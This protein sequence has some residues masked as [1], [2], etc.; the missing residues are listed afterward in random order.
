MSMMC[1][2]NLRCQNSR[3]RSSTVCVVAQMRRPGRYRSRS[4]VCLYWRTSISENQKRI[5]IGKFV[6]WTYL[7]G[8]NHDP[9]RQM[10]SILGVEG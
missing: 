9:S 1:T 7:T 3:A 5:L 2:E 10:A 8:A 6:K 4:F